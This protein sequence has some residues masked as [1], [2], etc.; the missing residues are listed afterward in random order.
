MSAS[1]KGNGRITRLTGTGCLVVFG[2]FWS[3]LTLVADA[4]IGWNILRQLHALTFSTTI[5]TVT[6]SQVKK[7]DDG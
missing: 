7:V 3:A 6:L 2:L 1:S 4:A 5:G